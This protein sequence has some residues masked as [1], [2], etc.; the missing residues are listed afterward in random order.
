MPLS[1]EDI[2]YCKQNGYHRLSKLL[3]EDL[4]EQLR[5]T[6]DKQIEAMKEP[7]VWETP[8]TRTPLS[9]RRLSK[10][11]DRD[12][13][14]YEAATHPFI[15]E[16]LENIIGPNIELLTNKH[17]HL[18]VRPPN[19]DVVRWHCGEEI[20]DPVLFTALIYLDESNTENGCIRL[21]PGSHQ[22]PFR[23]AVFKYTMHIVSLLNL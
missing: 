4:I 21:V 23:V 22:R 15:L 1:D 17:N 3:P 20:Y 5:D 12:P 7:I 8:K 10:I 2:W 19:S 16:I 11:L 13:I 18:M 9:I 14:Y 6:T